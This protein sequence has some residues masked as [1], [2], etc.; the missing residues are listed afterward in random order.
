MVYA[1]G[2][3]PRGSSRAV[4]PAFGGISGMQSAMLADLPDPGMAK[5]AEESGG[6]YV[7]VNYGQDLGRAFAQV[8]E[9]LHSQYLLGYTPPR[10]DGKT[11]RI[12]VRVTDKGMKPRARR[13]YIAPKS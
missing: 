3:R 11:H 7:E 8:A 5:V 13:S 1:V 4:P 6:G 2:M 10:R 9:E 12:E